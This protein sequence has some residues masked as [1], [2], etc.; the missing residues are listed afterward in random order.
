M[1]NRAQ[2]EIVAAVILILIVV[3]TAIIIMSFVVPFVK[4][5]LSSGDCLDVIDSVEI[6]NNVKYTCYGAGGGNNLLFQIH[7]GEN[8]SLKGFTLSLGS[9]SS[10]NYKVLPDEHLG[11]FPYQSPSGDVEVPGKNEE[12]TYI[13]YNVP[14]P[15]SITVYPI[16][17]DDK[18]C[19]QSD[20][21]NNIEDCLP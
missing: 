10:L 1:F 3:T 12:R 15:D 19:G 14:K 9:A 4:D 17:L 6:M 13:I 18:T 7:V 20:V 8:K 2:S 11:V 16:L 21:L 5:K